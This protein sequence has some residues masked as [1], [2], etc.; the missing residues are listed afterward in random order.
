MARIFWVITKTNVLIKD[1][2]PSNLATLEFTT[3]FMSNFSLST[4]V[5]SACRLRLDLCAQVNYVAKSCNIDKTPKYADWI[6]AK[7]WFGLV[8]RGLERLGEAWSALEPNNRKWRPRA[9][10]LRLRLRFKLAGLLNKLAR[11]SQKLPNQ[12]SGKK[13]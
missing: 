6:S 7:A 11:E 10:A 5:T 2:C 12:R 8:W 4:C 9:L 13:L 3:F 1:Y